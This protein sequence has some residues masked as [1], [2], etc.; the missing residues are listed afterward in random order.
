M[1]ISFQLTKRTQII[2]DSICYL[3]LYLRTQNRQFSLFVMV[4][5][6]DFNRFH[7]VD[8]RIQSVRVRNQPVIEPLRFQ[9]RSLQQSNLPLG[10][11]LELQLVDKHSLG[12]SA[13]FRFPKSVLD[14]FRLGHKRRVHTYTLPH[15]RRFCQEMGTFGV[16]FSS[17][18]ARW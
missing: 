2:L 4:S 11:V 12:F 6:L 16:V 13:I 9:K 10:E 8:S 18:R 3:L 1:T 17:P 7:L 5:H 14:S 15:P